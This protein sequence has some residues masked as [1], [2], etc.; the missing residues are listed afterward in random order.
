MNIEHWDHTDHQLIRIAE[1]YAEAFA[2]PPYGDDRERSLIEFPERVRR[3]SETKPE[4]RLLVATEGQEMVGFVL[5][6]GIGPGDWWWDRLNA[7]LDTQTR[8]TWLKPQQF[9]VAELVVSPA[10]RRSGVGQA[11]MREVLAGLPYDCALLACYPDAVA[12]QRL[13]SSLGWVVIEP[14]ARVSETRPTQILGIR[15]P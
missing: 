5:G 4:F 8:A 9:S 2:E 14:R 3:Y 15:L 12:P 11:L 1:L 13:Y 6:T 7:V 10:K